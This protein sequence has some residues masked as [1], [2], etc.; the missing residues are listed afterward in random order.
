[1]NRLISK[2]PLKIEVVNAQNQD[3]IKSIVIVITITKNVD[4]HVRAQ[5]AK[6]LILQFNKK[7][8]K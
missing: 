3:A 7:K 8:M 5:I 6:I 4:S 1:M 2:D